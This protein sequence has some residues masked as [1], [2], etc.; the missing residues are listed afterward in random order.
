MLFKLIIWIKRLNISFDYLDSADFGIFDKLI[1]YLLYSSL[2]LYPLQEISLGQFL[3]LLIFFVPIPQWSHPTSLFSIK[4][5]ESMDV[6]VIRHQIF[7]GLI[8]HSLVGLIPQ[9]GCGL[10]VFNYHCF[11]W[12][13][14]C[15]SL[16][17]LSKELSKYQVMESL[18]PY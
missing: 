9:L 11:V 17:F 18:R 2:S 7:F 15:H 5:I 1:I 3:A 16:K 6:I 12:V 10:L 8:F 4:T 14:L 13:A